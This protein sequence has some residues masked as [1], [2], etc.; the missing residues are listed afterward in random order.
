MTQHTNT[1]ILS[2]YGV[3]DLSIEYP[4][5]EVPVI[6]GSQRQGDV[7]VLKVTRKVDE[8]KAVALGNGVEVVRSEVGSGNTHTLHGDGVW[9]A[10]SGAASDLIQGW[11][12]VP[13]DGEA[14]LIHTEEH[15]AIGMAPGTYEIRRQ[16]EFAG[17]WHRVAD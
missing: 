5:L 15:N 2:R 16:R 10:N 7:L 4:E 17:E 8:S 6:G 11:L 12:L 1:S 13:A 3:N 9:L 14:F